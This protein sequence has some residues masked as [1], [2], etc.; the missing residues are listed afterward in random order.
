MVMTR[1]LFAASACTVVAAMVFLTSPRPAAQQGTFAIP[2]GAR[3]DAPDPNVPL[4]FEVASIKRNKEG[5][6]GISIQRQPG[7]RLNATNVPLNLLITFAYQLQGFQLV[8]LPNWARDERYD[9]VAK[10]TGDP[11]PVAPGAGPD[12]MMLAM[13]TLLADRFKLKIRKETREM[14]IYH[15]VMARSGG[16]PGPALKPSTDDCGPAALAARRGGGPGGQ[17]AGP[18]TRPDGTPILCG[19][20]QNFGR[21][22]FN[23]FP[24]SQFANS[25]AGQVGRVVVDRTGLT[26]E[27]SFEMTFQGEAPRGPLPPGVELP[28][29]DP[30]APTLFTALQEQL[31]LKLDATKGPVEVTVVE[32][33]ERPTE[34]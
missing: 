2:A 1:R 20:R 28:P 7:G 32:S 14:D 4:Y 18:P 21:I 26:G 19:I 6:G 11:A 3:A 24:L 8:D 33:I 12:H 13:R 34:D 9:I 22:Q 27:W 30:N 17:P 16:K 10:F 23:G 5:G 25:L 31:G 15:L 29:V